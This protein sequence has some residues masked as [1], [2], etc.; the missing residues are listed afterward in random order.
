MREC[1]CQK[2]EVRKM[3]AKRFDMHIY[4]DDCPYVCPKFDKWQDEKR[5]EVDDG[6]S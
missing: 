3:Y 1:P 5:K 4:G 2:C 6:N